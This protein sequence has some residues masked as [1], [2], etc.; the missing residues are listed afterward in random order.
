MAGVGKLRPRAKPA[1]P[2]GRWRRA[3]IWLLRTFLVL[4]LGP[5]LLKDAGVSLP[6]S[7]ELLCLGV[8]AV[9][10]VVGGWFLRK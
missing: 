5:P 2:S 3:R 7:A 8:G 1:V 9:A 6:V 4:L 10:I